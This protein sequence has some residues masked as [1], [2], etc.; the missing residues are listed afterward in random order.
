MKKLLILLCCL[1]FVGYM[2]YEND[3]FDYIKGD[4]SMV[5]PMHIE[6]EHNEY[7]RTASGNGLSPF[8]ATAI[9]KP[10]PNAYA[11]S[12]ALQQF[13]SYEWRGSKKDVVRFWDP[14]LTRA[15]DKIVTATNKG[16]IPAYVRVVFAF[17][18]LDA[19]L[20]KN[21]YTANGSNTMT[22]HGT[23]TIHGDQF[24]LFSY[25]YADVLKPG[26]T[27]MPSLL[28]VVLD[29]GASARDLSVIAGGYEIMSAT[30]AC[31]ADALPDSS[32]ENVDAASVLN[33]LL[34]P[35]STEQHPWIG[36]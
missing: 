35:I 19:T 11:E 28:Q 1:L 32:T 10:D 23:I 14:S 25:I 17:E 36:Q 8:Q 22:S 15:V 20:W 18:H 2:L 13:V 34:G 7:S 16:N 31:Q 30:Q 27:S 4:R 12:P 3:F 9:L 33:M 26:E 5:Q 24:D 6:I 21:V 29:A